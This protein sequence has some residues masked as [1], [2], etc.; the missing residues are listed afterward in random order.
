MPDVNEYHKTARPPRGSLVRRVVF[1]C[2]FFLVI[3]LIVYSIF[4]YYS[5]Y[6]RQLDEIVTSIEKLEQEQNRYIEGWVGFQ[7]DFLH[8]LQ[9]LMVERD[10][11][12]HA[13]SEGNFSELLKNFV[14]RG[15]LTAII[16]SDMKKC[17]NYACV[18]D[19]YPKVSNL[20]LT[21][22]IDVDTLYHKGSIVQIVNLP[23]WGYN[24]MISRAHIDEESRQMHGIL[25][26]ILS[27][28]VLVKRLLAMETTYPAMLSFIDKKGKILASSDAHL[29]EKD[30]YLKPIEGSNDAW[31]YEL[32]GDSYF[33]VLSEVPKFNCEIVMGVHKSVLFRNWQHYLYLLLGLL[34][35][36]L[37]VGGVATSIV[38]WRFSRPMRRLCYTMQS[39]AEGELDTRF[40]IDRVGFEINYIGGVFNQTVDSLI[41]HMRDLEQTHIEQ[42]VLSKELAIGQETQ[43]SILPSAIPDI[44]TLDIAYGFISAKEVG[45]D[46]YDV[47]LLDDN[48]LWI[49]IADTS[50]KG[51]SACLYSMCLRSMLR[52]FAKHN[53]SLETIIKA[54]NELFLDDTGNTGT[55]VTAWIGKIDL[56]SGKLRYS[57]LGHTPTLLKRSEG[58]IENLA[59]DGM[60][61][62]VADFTPDV[63]E[64][65]L[66]RGD[67]LLLYTDGITEAHNKADKLYGEERLN[68]LVGGITSESAHEIVEKVNGDVHTFCEGEPQHD[69]I[70]LLA[71]RKL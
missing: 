37:L 60:A 47:M 2:F 4:I 11:E 28:D 25:T 43:K 52:G 46:F 50:G 63:Q 14:K 26:T 24:L 13:F 67:L 27:L 62:G 18:T 22:F 56:N 12:G 39:V 54:S 51:V 49:C 3:P 8:T 45:G 44:N 68:Q 30:I 9:V 23:G 58:S 33:A 16:F 70:T 7:L 69:D 17:H 36:I 55:F 21:P 34:V 29:I 15:E 35:M 32:K 66:N 38:S 53:D 65:T 1:V 64:T 6:H 59:T 41:Q 31:S 19:S 57:S 61:L 5:E 42:E 20:D 48:K 40:E 71:I 10:T